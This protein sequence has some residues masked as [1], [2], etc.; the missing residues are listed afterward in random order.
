MSAAGRSGAEG[1]AASDV[2]ARLREAGFVRLAAAAHGDALAA[3]G[4]LATAL[5]SDGVPFQVSVAAHA[6]P[7][8]RSTD[9]DCTVA[10]GGPDV[11][12]DVTID[13]VSAPASRTAFE[14]ARA[15]SA[16]P[17]ATLALAG[18]IAAGASGSALADVAGL[19]RRPGAAVPTDDLADGLAHSTLIHAPFSGDPDAATETLSRIDPEADG[20]GRRVASL[21]ALATVEPDDA[22][23]RAAECVERA[24][25]PFA[26]GPL[27]TVGGYADVL[28]A[29]VRE[30]PG[31]AVALALGRTPDGALD[32]WR[33]HARRAHVAVRAA[34]TGRYDGLF[35]GRVDGDVP[36]WTVARLLRDFR[37][38]EP[39]VLV[40]T[41]GF[42][43]AAATPDAGVD[44]PSVFRM[45]LDPPRVV[46]TPR[47]VLAPVEGAA[48]AIVAVREAITR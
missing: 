46:G 30:E 29:V 18:T 48:D 12:A 19:E 3:A 22:T 23:P 27:R 43:A 40:A 14:A 28:D 35:V 44:L 15:L 37:S 41:D 45:A 38:P 25:R 42:A 24:L 20:A 36:V 39:V 2:A 9:A 16:E 33:T 17:D 4:V 47:Q 13:G 1:P 32:A 26:G 8:D 21:V 7:A 6:D 10:L 34:T 11:P 5:A 31:T